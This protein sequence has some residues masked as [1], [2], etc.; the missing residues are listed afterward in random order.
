MNSR[1]MQFFFLIKGQL[2]ADCIGSR[3]FFVEKIGEFKIEITKWT[4]YDVYNPMYHI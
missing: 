2:R 3:E 1:S 4:Y